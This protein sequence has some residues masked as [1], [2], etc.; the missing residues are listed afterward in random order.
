MVEL[1][2]DLGP[3]SYPVLIGPGQIDGLGKRLTDLVPG[4]RSL[5]VS[6]E[7]VWGLF[8]EAVTRSLEDAGMKVV[9]ALI[10]D[11]ES[12]KSLEQAALVYGRAVDG[13]LDR[14]SPVVALGGGV[15]G[16]LA[17]F[18][19]ATYQRGVPFVQVP[20]TLLAQVD[21][22]VGGKVA[23]NLPQG[24]NLVGAFHQPRL[25]LADT[26]TL[27]T[28]VPGEVAAGLAEIIKVAMIRDGAFFSWLEEN[29]EGL[30]RLDQGTLERAIAW[31]CGLKAQI[32][33]LDEREHGLRALLNFGHTFGHAVEYL[34]GYSVYNHGQAVAM[35]MVAAARL[36]VESG[37]LPEGDCLRLEE[38][39]ARA[40]LPTR[41]PG[42]FSIGQYI[43]S[44]HRDKKVFGDELTLVLPQAAGRGELVR[45][46]PE[47]RLAWFLGESGIM[48]NPG[49]QAGVKR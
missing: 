3:N 36:S 17:G 15:V 1:T 47:D 11:G 46:F 16:D 23:V 14:R 24:K 2:V 5:V 25:V 9:C 42:E 30:L 32:V 39:I 28:L 29:L 41:L 31:A 38:L 34:T 26:L 12:A 22:S 35:G 20:T 33:G 21:S 37:L 8:G 44:M 19:A 18:V 13:G 10:P 27:S 49:E 48:P 40:G 7:K 43:A 4:R 6:N 45:G